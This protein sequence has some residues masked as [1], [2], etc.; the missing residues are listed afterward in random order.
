ML[1]VWL[2]NCC[3]AFLTKNV[4]LWD[5]LLFQATFPSFMHAGKKSGD[6]VRLRGL[7]NK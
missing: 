2:Y 6:L 1:Y 4:F 5:G 7:L 3:K